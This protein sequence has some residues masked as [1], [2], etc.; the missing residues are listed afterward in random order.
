LKNNFLHIK[1]GIF[2][3]F[4]LSGEPIDAQSANWWVN[5]VESFFNQGFEATGCE[6]N[7]DA[8]NAYPTNEALAYYKAKC[9]Y[10]KGEFKSALTFMESYNFSDD[11]QDEILWLKINNNL[12]LNELSEAAKWADLLRVKFLRNK[13][14]ED[15]IKAEQL[16]NFLKNI[17][18]TNKNQLAYEAEITG[19]YGL[20]FYNDSIYFSS[21]FNQEVQQVFI[22]LND[23]L[24]NSLKG[25][26]NPYY[27]AKH[28]KLYFTEPNKGK[29]AQI[30]IAEINQKFQLIFKNPITVKGFE[31]VMQPTLF[32]YDNQDFLL[33]SGLKTGE[34][35]AQL[36]FVD[37]QED[38]NLDNPILIKLP[39]LLKGDYITPWFNPKQ[40]TLYFACNGLPG[41]GGY[42]LF[43]VAWNPKKMPSK[44]ENLVSLN[45]AFNEL[46]PS[47]QP[48]KNK[49]YFAS[50]RPKNGDWCCNNFY[51]TAQEFWP[52]PAPEQPN[53]KVIVEKLN[54]LLPLSLYF[55]NDSPKGKTGNPQSTNSNVKSLT[56]KYLAEQQIY[57]KYNANV[58]QFFDDVLSQ[59]IILLD[60]ILAEILTQFKEI[61]DFSLSLQITGFASPLA[62]E[63]YNND[64]SARRIDALKNYM[65]QW[66]Y[67]VLKPYIEKEKLQLFSLPLGMVND[68]FITKDI[69]ETVYSD[70]AIKS[71]KIEITKVVD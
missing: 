46:Y 19:N 55:D 41:F 50:N 27:F 34:K 37:F 24:L 63:S 3:L 45:T 51:F 67:G 17:G 62:P 18:P 36:F 29:S 12:M 39:S 71:R 32:E 49:F 66:N 65:L 68:T 61:E 6:T 21:T 13:K 15:Y 59:Q 25:A 30:Q 7:E 33:F 28:E 9:L 53:K 44:P 2:I 38:K 57:T 56:D 20:S 60:K 4:C 43:K 5:K 8:F 47:V 23:S 42:D 52:T 31:K 10:L 22:N 54:E 26:S 70:K 14:S 11:Y 64:L 69:S 58:N 40:D 35:N 16:L 48:N 1:L